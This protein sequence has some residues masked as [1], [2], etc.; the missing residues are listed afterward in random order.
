VALTFILLAGQLIWAAVF[1]YMGRSKVTAAQIRLY[2]R[3][4]HCPMARIST[5]TEF[6]FS[7][8]DSKIL[9]GYFTSR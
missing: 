5:L 9:T 3:S 2:V 4:D 1:V 6:S 8:Y 7:P